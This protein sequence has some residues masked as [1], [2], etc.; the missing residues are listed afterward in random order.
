[1]GQEYWKYQI[2]VDEDS[3]KLRLEISIEQYIISIVIWN[4]HIDIVMLECCLAIKVGGCLLLLLL[5]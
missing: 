3:M 4:M 2:E 1:M 5:F